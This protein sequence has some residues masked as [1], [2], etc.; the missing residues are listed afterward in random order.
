M[1]LDKSFFEESKEQSCVKITIVAKYFKVWAKVISGALR[2]G[3]HSN[4][5]NRIAYID[6]FSGPGLY[7]DGTKSTPILILEEAIKDEDLRGRLITIFNDKDPMIAASLRQA[8][9]NIPGI[10]TLKYQPQVNTQEVGEEIVKVIEHEKNIPTLFFIDPWGYKGLS[11]ELLKALIGGWGCDCV[12][13]FNYNRINRDLTNKFVADH[14]NAL[15]GEKGA[16]ALRQDLLVLSP[17]KRELKIINELC[18]ALKGKGFPYVLPFRFKNGNGSRTMHHL[19]FVSKHPT[20]YEKM[21]GIMASESSRTEQGVPSFEY[22]PVDVRDAGCQKFLFELPRP[23]DDL[24]DMLLDT[25]EGQ[26]LTM[27][28]IYEKHSVDRPYIKKNYKD[29]LYKLEEDGKIMASNHR[30]NSFADDVEV[31]FPSK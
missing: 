16:D 17:L 26:T 21:K 10:N 3:F 22:N 25:F 11:L 20:G 28:Q 18:Q 29:V 14:M 31:T 24:A 13:F 7:E 5:D 19:I 2:K 15:F 6:L 12:F 1:V 9:N 8:I 30:R 27:Y 4:M 23:L